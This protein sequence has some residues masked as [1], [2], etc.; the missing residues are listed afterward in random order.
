VIHTT[1]RCTIGVC[2]SCEAKAHTYWAPLD[3]FD[4]SPM[5]LCGKCVAAEAHNYLRKRSDVQD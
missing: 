3:E 5:W 1:I 2:Y 4:N